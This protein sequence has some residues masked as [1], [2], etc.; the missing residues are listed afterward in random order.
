MMIAETAEMSGSVLNW[1]DLICL[2][3]LGAFLVYGVVRGFMIQLLGIGVLIGSV[4]LASLFCRPLGRF[5][6]GKWP[7]LGAETAKWVAFGILFIVTLAVGTALAHLLK[8]SLS[9]AK[10]LAYDRLLGA[11]LGLAKGWI[12]A[13]IVIQFALNLTYAGGEPTGLAK[14][15]VESRSGRIARWSTEKIFVFLPPETAKDLQKY[16]KLH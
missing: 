2:A 3:I 4:L 15:I 11:G 6:Y 13:V 12:L 14:D 9:K 8:G 10:M 7:S 16:D 1:V 5:L